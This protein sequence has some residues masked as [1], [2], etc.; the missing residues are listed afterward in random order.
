MAKMDQDKCKHEF[1][2]KNA[3]TKGYC[4]KH[5]AAF[6]AKQY[7]Y[8]NAY[9]RLKSNAKRRAIP[10]YLTLEEFKQFADSTGYINRRGRTKYDLHIDRIDCTKGY[11]KDNIQV[12]TNLQN[13]RKGVLEK[14]YKQKGITFDATLLNKQL[15]RQLS[16]FEMPMDIAQ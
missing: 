8:K 14:L 4:K 11:S 7:P 5:Y 12:L 3:N 13:A 2:N 10:F 16:L 9:S 6:M 1:C 15:K